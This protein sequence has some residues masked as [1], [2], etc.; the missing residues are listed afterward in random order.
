MITHHKSQQIKV[1]LAVFQPLNN[2]KQLTRVSC[3]KGFCSTRS[4]DNG[5]LFIL[6]IFSRTVIASSS[7]PFDKSH[8][9]DSDT[10]LNNTRNKLNVY[11]TVY[12]EWESKIEIITLVLLFFSKNIKLCLSSVSMMEDFS[13]Y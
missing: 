6:E 2:C 8:R 13:N 7:L 12:Q 9:G 10:S 1:F 3:F 4:S 5:R 11:R